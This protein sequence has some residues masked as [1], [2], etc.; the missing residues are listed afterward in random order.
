MDSI[1]TRVYNNFIIDKNFGTITKISSNQKLK[2]EIS[3]LQNIS[4]TNLSVFFPR[5][6]KT[7]NTESCS[8]TMELYSY[9]DLA[10]K[11]IN[12]PF[13]Q[14]EWYK[15]CNQILTSLQLFEKETP[16]SINTNEYKD[17]FEKIYITKTRNEFL[18]LFKSCKFF[19]DL[20]SYRTLVINGVKYNNFKYIENNIYNIITKNLLRG[21][22]SIIHGDFCFGNILHSIYKDSCILKFIDPRGSWGNDGIY[23][24]KR[25]D[26]AKI[27]HSFDGCYEY[28]TNDKFNL[29][30][31]NNKIDF[32]FFNSNY[33]YISNIFLDNIFKT[34]NLDISEIKLI[35]GLLF[36]SMCARHYDSLDRQ[37]IMY[38]TGVRILNQILNKYETK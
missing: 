9:E 19:N 11:M 18:S 4:K 15:I 38:A 31:T 1:V 35:E 14:E 24:D 6:L 29:K 27:L 36:I 10:H 16:Q 34:S 12:K 13:N 26:F 2:D 25:Y 22:I 21:D 5:V 3:Y 37:I 33:R 8:V 7:Q 17:C 30:Y 23:G 28:I 20:L 32:E